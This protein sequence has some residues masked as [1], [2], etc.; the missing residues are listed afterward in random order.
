MAQV[1]T[2]LY[3]IFLSPN[4]PPHHRMYSTFI[5]SLALQRQFARHQEL[6]V[7]WL[8]SLLRRLL[9]VSLLSVVLRERSLQNSWMS[10]SLVVPLSVE[11]QACKKLGET[12][13]GSLFRVPGCC[14]SL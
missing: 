10:T 2:T 12:N 13:W 5:P 11:S 9:A 4:S 6:E 7:I 8:R 3:I 1:N 14:F